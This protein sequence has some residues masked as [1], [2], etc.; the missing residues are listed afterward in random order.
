MRKW[1]I[2]NPQTA[3]IVR[4]APRMYSLDDP[5]AVSILYSIASPHVKSAWYSAFADPRIPDHNLFSA[6]TRTFHAAMRRKMGHMYSMSS[7][8]SYEPYVN[9]CIET[10]LRQLDLCAAR[11][12]EVDLQRWMQSYA[13]DVIGA[14]TVRNVAID[15]NSC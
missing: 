2:A 12:Q 15:L 10:L 5:A 14:I 1:L 13:F 9:D 7:I 3:K 8:K 11:G 6:R 4:V